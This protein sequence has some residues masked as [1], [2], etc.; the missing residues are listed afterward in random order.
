MARIQVMP[1]TPVKVDG[2]ERI[3]FV[4]I[5]DQLGDVRQTDPWLNTV[6]LGEALKQQTGA[7]SVWMHEGTFDVASPLELTEEQR[8]HLLDVLTPA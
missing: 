3:P 2:L 6:E 8:R 7:E 5:I 4:L 1:L